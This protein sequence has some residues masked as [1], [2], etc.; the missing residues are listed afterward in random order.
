MGSE[1]RHTMPISKLAN[2]LTLD[3]RIDENIYFNHYPRKSKKSPNGFYLWQSTYIIGNT[4][5]IDDLQLTLKSLTMYGEWYHS[6]ML[7][8]DDKGTKTSYIN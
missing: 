3:K 4:D 5:T 2:Y 7:S 8:V 6:F 1:H